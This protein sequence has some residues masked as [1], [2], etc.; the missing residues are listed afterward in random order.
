M[1]NTITQYIIDNDNTYPSITL[2][3]A[4]IINLVCTGQT[5]SSSGGCSG[6]T[7]VGFSYSLSV[8]LA[9]TAATKVVMVTTAAATVP[10]TNALSCAFVATID[11]A[12]VIIAMGAVMAGP[13]EGRS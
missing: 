11:E 4:N 13:C 6:G 2:T 3:S 1:L 12:I 5:C 7:N 10:R 9:A 8:T